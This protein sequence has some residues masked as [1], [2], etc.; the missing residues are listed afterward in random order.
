[1]KNLLSQIGRIVTI[2]ALSISVFGGATAT[3]VSA[4]AGDTRD[5]LVP[6]GEPA[7]VTNYT[8]TVNDVTTDFT[9]SYT[10]FMP[11]QGFTPVQVSTTVTNNSGQDVEP[12]WVL[13]V[14]V[15]GNDGIVHSEGGFCGAETNDVVDITNLAADETMDV[16]F[17]FPVKE[18][19]EDSIVLVMDDILNVAVPRPV[20]FS[21]G[22]DDNVDPE[23]AM[24]HLPALNATPVAQ[25]SEGE[26]AAIR[27]VVTVDDSDFQMLSFTPNDEAALKAALDQDAADQTNLYDEDSAAVVAH[28]KMINKGGIARDPYV[29]YLWSFIGASGKEYDLIKVGCPTYDSPLLDANELYPGGYTEFNICIIVPADEV[30]GGLIKITS[31]YNAGD[32]QVIAAEE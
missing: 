19:Q 13:S 31:I 32:F 9:P 3:H 24:N 11:D 25:T 8:V 15:V 5:N 27:D 20:Y 30:D 21:L 7:E 18:G 4:A 12:F 17:C 16:N 22:N 2:G 23:W 10:D 28:F 6:I 29:H 1:M 14:S 26:P